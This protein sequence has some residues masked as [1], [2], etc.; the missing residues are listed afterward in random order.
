MWLNYVYA[1][2]D[3]R[4]AWPDIVSHASLY[5]D[6]RSLVLQRLVVHEFGHVLGTIDHWDMP[7]PYGTECNG[8]DMCPTK[9]ITS[10]SDLPGAD[11]VAWRAWV[12]RYSDNTWQW[13]DDPAWDCLGHLC[14]RP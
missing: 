14:Y 3:V 8:D 13:C 7:P 11:E 9:S 1:M 5:G 10:C 4:G 6:V 2:A 12:N